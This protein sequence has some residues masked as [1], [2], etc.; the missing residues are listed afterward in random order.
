M[1]KVRFTEEQMVAIL[2]EAEQTSV[3]E[4]ARKHKISEQTIYNWRRHFGRLDPAD[5]KRFREPGRRK[6]Q[7]Q[8]HPRRPR[9]RDRYAQ[10]DQSPKVVSSQARR[11]QVAFACECG[12][13]KRR[14]C[15]LL[16]VARSALA[17]RSVRAERDA[18]PLAAMKRLAAQYPR[19]GYR[20]IRIF[21]VARAIT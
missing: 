16:E 14:A 2:R 6:R 8:A 19:Y 9:S 7:A 15:E 5:I 4:V 1:K 18:P 13:S 20:R 11:E 12:L 3:A 21:F 10:G 17:Y